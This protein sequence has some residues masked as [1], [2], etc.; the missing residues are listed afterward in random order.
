MAVY[1]RSKIQAFLNAGAGQP[2]QVPLTISEIF[3][4][5]KSMSKKRT[6][7]PPKNKAERKDVDLRIPVTAEQKELVVQAARIEGADMAA[8]VRPIVILAAEKLVKARKP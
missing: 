1:D 5:N 8:W 2:V 6:G 3:S 4:Y 7:R